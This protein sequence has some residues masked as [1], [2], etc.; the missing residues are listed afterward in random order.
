MKKNQP[1]TKTPVAL[2][3]DPNIN[4]F[5]YRRYTD[6]LGARVIGWL[7]WIFNNVIIGKGGKVNQYDQQFPRT[8]GMHRT[9]HVR[10]CQMHKRVWL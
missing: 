7:A 2:T 3:D 9:K 5:V 10:L 8:Q 4:S 6:I 1:P